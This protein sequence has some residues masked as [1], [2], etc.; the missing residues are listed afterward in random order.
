MTASYDIEITRDWAAFAP[1]W[2]AIVGQLR[3]SPFQKPIWLANWYGAM[4]AATGVAPLFVAVR[5][6]RTG[7]DVLL[8]P[9][10][11][12]RARGLDIVEFADLD[13]TDCNAPAVA[14]G[15]LADPAAAADAIA[16]VRAALPRCD[17]LRLTKMPTM[18]GGHA[19]PLAAPTLDRPSTTDSL[20]TWSVHAPGSW[21]DYLKSLDR[22]TRKELGRSLR[23]CEQIGPTRLVRARTAAE[24]L[25]I[26]DVVDALQ[27]ERLARTQTRHVFDDPGPRNFYRS[28]VTD[29]VP[30]GDTLAMGLEIGGEVVAGVIGVLDRPRVTVLRIANRT[31]DY[32]RIGLGRVLL[33]QT[34]KAL[35]AEGFTHL[36]LSIGDGEHKRRLGGTSELLV[37]RVEAMSL[38]GGMAIAAGRAKALVKRRLPAAAALASRLRRPRA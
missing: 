2:S 21:D 11:T 37:E 5:D 15:L 25:A 20:P 33:E 1:R 17:V 29:G 22:Y 10:V 7:A 32:A 4:P 9:L 28:L 24:G 13:I 18:I 16:A 14:P 35:H 3:A 34:F 31:G 30:D 38:R 6:R 27:R 36:D 12:R 23:L 26:L 8:L 19:N